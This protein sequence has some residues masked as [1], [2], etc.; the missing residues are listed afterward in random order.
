MRDPRW[1]LDER[2]LGKLL[3]DDKGENEPR[4]VHDVNC[5]AGVLV[6]RHGKRTDSLDDAQAVFATLAHGLSKVREAGTWSKAWVDSLRS[7]IT[8][9]FQTVHG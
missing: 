5:I 2:A 9:S 3:A 7:S 4:V 6:Y 8:L 1:T